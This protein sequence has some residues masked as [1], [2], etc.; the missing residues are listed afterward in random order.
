MEVNRPSVSR[1]RSRRRSFTCERWAT[2]S[3]NVTSTRR[4]SSRR[5][6]LNTPPR[7]TRTRIG[8]HLDA[9]VG[10]AAVRDHDQAR[11][12]DRPRRYDG[13]SRYDAQASRETGDR[14]SHA[15]TDEIGRAP[16]AG[17]LD[18]GYAHRHFEQ[19]RD[20]GLPPTVGVADGVDRAPQ[21]IGGQYRPREPGVLTD[22]LG[23]SR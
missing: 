2:R 18:H 12:H 19:Q 1:W 16:E 5:Y 20:R 14:R 11:H 21:G 7:A 15:Q 3:T 22:V 4:A 10:D 9:E 13:D 23:G 17:E 6:R 8:R